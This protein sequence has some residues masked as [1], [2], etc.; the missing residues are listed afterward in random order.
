MT[1]L[2]SIIL[3][4]ITTILIASCNSDYK[5]VGNLDVNLWNIETN[6]FINDY[7]SIEFLPTTGYP[8]ANRKNFYN[9]LHQ[10][11][12]NQRN[13]LK[14]ELIK[15]KVDFTT[16]I[17]EVK[18]EYIRGKN[19]S[20]LPPIYW[21]GDSNK[22]YKIYFN[23]GEYQMEKQPFDKDYLKLNYDDK[24]YQNLI[25]PID[26]GQMSFVISSTIN[27]GDLKEINI[28]KCSINYLE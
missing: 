10:N 11:F 19:D 1:I 17:I 23:N 2:K 22:L 7:C 26:I 14:K 24:C 9:Y 16:E 25:G 4:I 27:L 21:I 13:I 8:V 5:N 3:L 18:E 20:I 15:N 12:L 6:N 28:N